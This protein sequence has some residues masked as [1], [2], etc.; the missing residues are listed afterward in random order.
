M[1]SKAQL[2]NSVGWGED[3]TWQHCLRLVAWPLLSL[4]TKTWRIPTAT[5]TLVETR[6]L[7]QTSSL[8]SCVSQWSAELCGRE[9]MLVEPLCLQFFSQGK[10]M[11]GCP[12]MC[13]I[14]HHTQTT[15]LYSDYEVRF[16]A[17]C[18]CKCQWLRGSSRV[19]SEL[20]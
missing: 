6:G 10:C 16:A 4:G 2:L 7:E 18:N 14:A 12:S 5:A 13:S 9:S 19:P 17:N 1:K 20:F 8:T 11:C 3:N 15:K